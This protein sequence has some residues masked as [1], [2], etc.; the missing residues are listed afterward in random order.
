MHRVTAKALVLVLLLGVF[1][2]FAAFA[3]TAPTYATGDHCTRL[4]V[5]RQVEASSGCHHHGSAATPADAPVPR[6]DLRSK[7]C[8]NGHE[9]CRLQ[10]RAQWAQVA[11]R[12]QLQQSD[13]IEQFLSGSTPQSH[14]S[15]VEIFRPVRAPPIV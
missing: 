3:S 6:T 7:P 14:I 15:H 9:C 12:T 11:L 2:P 1:T 5:T 13:F 10:V 4:P 8:C